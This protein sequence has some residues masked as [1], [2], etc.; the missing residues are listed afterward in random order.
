MSPALFSKLPVYTT[1]FLFDE[2]IHLVHIGV[3]VEEDAAL[4]TG[5]HS[6]FDSFHHYE[7]LEYVATHLIP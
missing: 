1:A 3:A 6:V 7:V 2:Y 4:L 5:I